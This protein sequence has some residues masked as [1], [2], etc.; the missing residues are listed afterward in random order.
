[1]VARR[2]TGGNGE[3]PAPSVELRRDHDCLTLPMNRCSNDWLPPNASHTHQH[4]HKLEGAQRVHISAKYTIISCT[5]L[6]VYIRASL[7]MYV[8]SIRLR[9][10]MTSSLHAWRAMACAENPSETALHFCTFLLNPHFDL[11]PDYIVRKPMKHRFQRYIVR[12]EVFST[13]HA[14]VEYISVK[15]VISGKMDLQ[16]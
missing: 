15:T 4:K 2:S 11:E 6:H 16:R 13:F 8:R 9:T 14:R 10:T 12:T 1:M 3:P 5:R 7:V